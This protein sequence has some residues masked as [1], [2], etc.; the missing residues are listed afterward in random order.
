MRREPATNLESKTMSLIQHQQA[1][2]AIQLR[3][4]LE[5]AGCDT[6]VAAIAA[7]AVGELIDHVT[8]A[9]ERVRRDIGEKVFEASMRGNELS[10]YKRELFDRFVGGTLLVMAAAV[11]ACVVGVLI[12]MFR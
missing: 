2:Y 10:Q 9:E 11:V 5:Q 4:R 7:C 8:Q 1:T 3:T 12:A 6:R